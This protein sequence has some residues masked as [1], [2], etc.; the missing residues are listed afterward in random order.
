MQVKTEEIFINEQIKNKYGNSP[1]RIPL[2]N[3]EGVIVE[4]SLVDK[5]QFE[6]VNKY[7]W[8]LAPGGY[9]QSMIQGNNRKMHHFIFQKPKEGYVIDHINEDKLDNR[10]SNLRE[11]THSENNHNRC[12][13]KQN[14]TS[15]FKGVYKKN[16]NNKSSSF[17]SFYAKVRLYQGSDE[18]QAALL[19][20][21]YT[22]QLFGENANN[23]R[24]ISYEEAM[25]Y[26]FPEKKERPLPQ[27]ITLMNRNGKERFMV[28]RTFR[29]VSQKYYFHNL[30]EAIAKV[31]HINFL[32]KLTLILEEK[33]HRMSEIQRN[34]DGIAYVVAS[35]QRHILV[36]DE[37]WH[38]FSKQS[39]YIDNYGY[40]LNASN[41][42]M[43]KLLVKCDDKS[44]VIHHRNSNTLDNRR[45]NLVVATR[46]ENAHQKKK[47]SNTS[48]KYFGVCFVK[49]LSK[50]ES[51]FYKNGQKYYVGVFENEVD[52]ARAYNEKVKQIF[53]EFANLNVIEE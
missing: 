50:W 17:T 46:S 48:S 38:D 45:E 7:K 5:K 10:L 20:D 44:K 16:N 26:E 19:Y 30:E 29:G 22:Y 14:A 33:Q 2:R 9:G 6:R 41:K 43:H 13:R 42:K 12:K 8:H 18:R 24:L 40:A 28:R 32:I 49:H 3:R 4:F 35:D 1:Y 31:E 37:D 34:E 23:N 51:K 21:I 25:K 27:H 11:I 15:Q 52:A 47:R 53:G 39:W 36:S